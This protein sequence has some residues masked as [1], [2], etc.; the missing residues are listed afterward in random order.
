[1]IYADMG[2]LKKLRLLRPLR[3]LRRPAE[4]GTPRNDRKC[5]SAS[6]RAKPALKGRGEISNLKLQ[7]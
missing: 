1:M 7:M 5:V 2:L 3:G 6:L 4:I